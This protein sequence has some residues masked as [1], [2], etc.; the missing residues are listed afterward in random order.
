MYTFAN[1]ILVG[2]IAASVLFSPQNARAGT[3]D[4][5]HTLTGGFVGGFASIPEYEGSDDQRLIPLV[6]GNIR[7]GNRYLSLQGTSLRANTLDSE[8]FEL[9]PVLNLN[10]GRDEDIDAIPVRALGVIDDAYELGVFAAYKR[11][12]GPHTWRPDQGRCADACRYQ[13][14]A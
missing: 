5:S 12:L 9:G 7:I 3:S 2:F 11:E 8:H 4:E 10:F 6:A 13:R 1:H 14:R